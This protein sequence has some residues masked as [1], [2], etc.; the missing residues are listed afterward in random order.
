MNN[1]VVL[2][3]IAIFFIIELEKLYRRVRFRL[4]END[5]RRYHCGHFLSYP[6]LGNP[7]RNKAKEL[8]TDRLTDGRTAF[9]ESLRN[10]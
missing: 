2:D 9:I 3:G 10:D 6:L 8:P 5:D 4:K 7:M 1:D